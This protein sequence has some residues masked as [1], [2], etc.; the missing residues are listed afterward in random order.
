[1]PPKIDD[2]RHSIWPRPEL[3]FD[4]GERLSEEGLWDRSSSVGHQPGHAVGSCLCE[5]TGPLVPSCG[6]WALASRSEFGPRRRVIRDDFRM[7][8]TCNN[9]LRTN[10]K[11]KDHI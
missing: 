10:S 5:Q 4:V 2:V 6:E 9:Q 11:T 3:T 1:M 7:R 8:A